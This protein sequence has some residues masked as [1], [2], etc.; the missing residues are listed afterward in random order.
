M[1]TLSV[2]EFSK[3]CE[4]FSPGYYIF[5]SRNQKHGDESVLRVTAYLQ[6]MAV[7]LA[8]NR[9]IFRGESN[10]VCIEGVDRIDVEDMIADGQGYFVFHVIH[11]DPFDP[12]SYTFIA[13]KIF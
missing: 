10:Q 3:F 6:E 11:D 12:E 8:P 4:D 7:Q 2:N 1:T 13:Q 5:D 9:I